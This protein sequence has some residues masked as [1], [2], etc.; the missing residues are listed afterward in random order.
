MLTFFKRTKPFREHKGTIRR[1]AL[2]KAAHADVESFLVE[3]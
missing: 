2:K 3:N 1:N